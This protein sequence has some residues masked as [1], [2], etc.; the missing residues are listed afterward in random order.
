MPDGLRNM[1]VTSDANKADGEGVSKCEHMQAN[2]DMLTPLCL[3]VCY[4]PLGHPL[5]SVLKIWPGPD[6]VLTCGLLSGL[7]EGFIALSMPQHSADY[8]DLVQSKAIQ[9]HISVAES[10]VLGIKQFRNRSH[11][12]LAELSCGGTLVRFSTPV[13]IMLFL[14]KRTSTTILSTK[15]QEQSSPEL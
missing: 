8:H 3:G 10:Q 2:A 1:K 14:V 5:V 9:G 7:M 11:D 4:T 15:A 12:V 13:E 6:P